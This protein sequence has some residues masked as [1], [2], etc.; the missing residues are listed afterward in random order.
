MKT[1]R[2]QKLAIFVGAVRQTD[3]AHIQD[4]GYDIALF[5]DK[6]CPLVPSHNPRDFRL[7]CS[8]D[9]CTAQS[10]D[11]LKLLSGWYDH[12]LLLTTIETSVLD[13]AIIARKHGYRAPTVEAARS[14][15]DKTEMR[16]RFRESLGQ[17]KTIPFALI[18]NE[19]DLFR[20]AGDAGF[21]LVLK[22]VNLFGSMFVSLCRSER[23]S[24]ETY[25]KNRILIRDFLNRLGREDEPVLIQAESFISG[26]CLSV[27]VVVDS[28]GDFYPTPVVDIWTNQ[29]FSRAGFAHLARFLPSSLSPD[30]QEKAVALA[31]DAV[32]ALGLTNCIAHVEMIMGAEGPKLLEAAARIGGGR[33]ALVETALGFSL[34]GEYVR[35]LRGD[36]PVMAAPAM[37]PGRAKFV[38]VISPFP[39]SPGF[40]VDAPGLHRV[41]KACPEFVSAVVRAKPG[42]RIGPADAG[43]LPP[44]NLTLQSERAK[45]L[46]D[47]ARSILDDS[48]FYTL[49]V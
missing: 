1:V 32:H 22:P 15:L 27:D 17:D 31:G 39:K 41:K 28:K 24:I 29:D 26:R 11:L 37:N 16:R 4:M 40:Y 21:P 30:H 35:V 48:H 34:I 3:Y 7:I 8:L 12:T 43:F 20:F 46:K 49:C 23:E 2:K 18:K 6:T 45:T 13:H 10:D 14:A 19:K 47:V 38:S 33:N 44:A 42:E 25:R 9:C 5:R 36:K